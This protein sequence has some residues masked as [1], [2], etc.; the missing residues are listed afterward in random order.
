M[1]SNTLSTEQQQR[2]VCNGFLVLREAIP[3]DVL[4]SVCN[5]ITNTLPEELNDFEKLASGPKK[6]HEWIETEDDSPFDKLNQHLY[7]YASEIV[8]DKLNPTTPLTQIS[9]RYPTGK[10][11]GSQNRPSPIEGVYHHIDAID[12]ESG[13]LQPFSVGVGTYINEVAPRSGGFCVWP[14]SHW[15]A[16]ERVSEHG[17]VAL[18]D[19]DPIINSTNAPFEVTG[20]AG[21]IFLYHHLLVHGGGV[22][23]GRQPRLATFTRF[24]RE[25]IGDTFKDSIKEPF[26]FCEG[27]N[28]EKCHRH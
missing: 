19:V 3:E 2:F 15:H 26:K 28:M 10:H 6:R 5:E 11:P 8:G 17:M 27:L 22:H 13:N 24:L 16:A 4:E 21:T 25:D 20:Q 1:A 23:L 18:Q 7:K 14:G 12:N 9:A